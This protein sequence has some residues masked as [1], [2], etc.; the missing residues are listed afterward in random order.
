MKKLELIAA[1]K[2]EANISRLGRSDRRDLL[3]T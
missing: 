3:I 1:L 2:T